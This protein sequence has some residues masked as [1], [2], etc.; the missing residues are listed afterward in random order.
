MPFL[1]LPVVLLLL[2]AQPAE[3]A[4]A[5][6][7]GADG[8]SVSGSVHFTRFDEGVRVR[9]QVRGLP[10]GLHGFHIHAGTDCAAPGSSFD[11]DGRPHGGPL[12]AATR[13]HAGDLGNLDADEGLAR[14]D[15][16]DPVL[17]L[18]GSATIVGRVVVVHAGQ[19]DLNTL[20]DGGAGGVV[21]C[22]VIAPVR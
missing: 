9:A 10:D 13:R 20:P 22:G 19:D 11:P 21:A 15:R 18:D 17:A 12:D 1:L 7:R 16:L 5:E 14:Y 8:A 6:L 4:V 2:S 3:E